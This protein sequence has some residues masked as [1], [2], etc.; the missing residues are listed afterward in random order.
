MT[1]ADYT[2]A[3]FF[4]VLASVSYYVGYRHGRNDDA[5]N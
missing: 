1:T 4:L 5:P 2:T 3:V